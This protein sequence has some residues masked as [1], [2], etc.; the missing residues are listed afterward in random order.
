[1]RSFVPIVFAFGVWCS[2][3]A[4]ANDSTNGLPL[5]D[6]FVS[7]ADGFPIFRI[8][9]IVMARDGNLLAFAE[10][11]ASKRDQSENKIVLKVS[12]DR[13]RSWGKIR[14]LAD[15]GTNSLNNPTAVVLRETGRIILM[16][17]Q[18]LRGF[19]EQMAE[20]GLKGSHICRSFIIHSDDNGVNWSKP[21]DIT[22]SVKRPIIV[23]GI[24]SGPGIGI[25]L[26]RGTHPGRILI[27]FNQGPRGHWEVYAAFS[28]DAGETWKYGEVAPKDP[29]MGPNEVQMA[30]LADGAVM[31]N[32]RDEAGSHHRLVAASHDGGETW[33]PLAPDETLIEPRCEASLLRHAINNH[34]SDDVLLF[35]N[36]AS[37]KKRINGTV[38]LSRDEGKTWSAS[39]VIYPGSFA[40]SCLVSLNPQTIG[41]LFERDSYGKISFAAFTLDWVTKS[42]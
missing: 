11:R 26:A 6:V 27:P 24:A 10:G 3:N 33:T 14:V 4:L 18:Y 38:R 9:S 41:C 15:D 19:G 23:T 25:E 22:A 12:S 1:L 7:G 34:V 35:S 36:P 29:G 37:E 8:P 31:L 32:A 28:D 20:A 13:G 42:E 16:Y 21:Q 5:T 17:Q 30:E 2:N 40:Y 39:R